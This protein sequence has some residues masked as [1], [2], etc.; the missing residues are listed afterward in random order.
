MKKIGSSSTIGCKSC[1]KSCHCG[2]FF[3]R[4]VEKELRKGSV[5]R[6][7]INAIFVV[8]TKLT[9]NL[10]VNWDENLRKKDKSG[11]YAFFIEGVEEGVWRIFGEYC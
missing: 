4:L 6:R 5:N 11:D 9:K 2:S 7:R 8:V 10:Q 1:R 3:G